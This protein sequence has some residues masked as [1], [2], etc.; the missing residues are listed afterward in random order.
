MQG[1]MAVDFARFSK[2][3]E[4]A[5]PRMKVFTRCF[6]APPGFRRPPRPAASRPPTAR[7]LRRALSSIFNL[8]ASPMYKNLENAKLSPAL[9]AEW[10]RDG[11]RSSKA[12]SIR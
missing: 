2:V 4:D 5:E 12:F 1:V 10:V 11:V 9:L 7:E 8:V 6:S 3:I